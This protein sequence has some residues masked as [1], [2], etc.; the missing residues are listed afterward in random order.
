MGFEGRIIIAATSDGIVHVIDSASFDVHIHIANH[1]G[2]RIHCLEQSTHDDH[3]FLV[4]DSHQQVS[5]WN[6]RVADGRD[7]W[8]AILYR[9]IN[10][11]QAFSAQQDVFQ[12]LDD[13]PGFMPPNLASTVLI[14][15]RVEQDV[16]FVM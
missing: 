9:W 12:E 2:N 3:L 5:L 11:S 7:N 14:A 16:Q 1:S 6:S 8:D 10:M 15:Y 4:C 13:V